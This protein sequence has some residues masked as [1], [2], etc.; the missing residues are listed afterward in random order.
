MWKWREGGRESRM[1]AQGRVS[2]QLPSGFE[3]KDSKIWDSGIEK[4]KEMHTFKKLGG[5][6]DKLWGSE[7]ALTPVF[8]SQ[9]HLLQQQV[10]L[11]SCKVTR[12]SSLLNPYCYSYHLHCSVPCLVLLQKASSDLP[13][14]N[15]NPFSKEQLECYLGMGN[16]FHPLPT[17]KCSLVGFYHIK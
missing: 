8:P 1:E 3:V 11:L 12:P 9:P 17:L 4:K 7:S 5:R 6:L 14:S 15:H 10:Y 2:W 16:K 13:A